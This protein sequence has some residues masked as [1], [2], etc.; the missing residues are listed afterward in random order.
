MLAALGGCRKS[1]EPS[2]AF[3]QA[4]SRHLALLEARGEEGYADPEAVAILQL[5]AQVP[6]DSSDAEAARVMREHIEAEQAR[7]SE[8]QRDVASA[9]AFA[10]EAPALTES[11]PR[12][13]VQD[14]TPDAGAAD[15]GTP[16]PAVG[17]TVAELSAKFS[18]CF[19]P[20]ETLFLPDRGDRETWARKDL[21]VCRE[22]YPQFDR[23]V[24]LIENGKVFAYGQRGPVMQR[25]EDGGTVPA[26]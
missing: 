20:G 5:L 7:L 10:R 11:A 26:L 16:L 25:L 6:A 1:P 9:L 17:M 14:G 23:T 21:A 13:L 22:L 15:A 12:E 3:A 2:A 4:R 18:R 19:E 24:L 8:R